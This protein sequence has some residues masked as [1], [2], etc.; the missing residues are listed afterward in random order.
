MPRACA[1]G[2][3]GSGIL[4]Q[5]ENCLQAKGLAEGSTSAVPINRPQGENRE[6]RDV[7]GR[8]GCPPPGRRPGEGDV[9]ATRPNGR[10]ELRYGLT[11]P[12]PGMTGTV[13]DLAMYA[14]RGVD[15]ITD[16][17]GAGQ[18]IARLWKECLDAT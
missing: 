16:V 14:G 13:T 7:E 17:P 4:P 12:V 15:A 11:A 5:Q 9:V 1:A 18:L 2:S 10:Q 8:A 6:N 3:E